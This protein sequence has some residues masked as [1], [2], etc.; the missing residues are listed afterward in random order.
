MNF[1]TLFLRGI[2]LMPSVVQGVESLFG[3]KSGGQKKSAVLSV[4][5]A[6]INVVDAIEHKTIVD[7]TG[8]TSGLGMVVDGVVACLNASIWF[9]GSSSAGAAT[10]TTASTP[11]ATS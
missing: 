5:T 1:L 6:A 3:A 8:F 9:S 11:G 7:A 4:V 10:G 2:A